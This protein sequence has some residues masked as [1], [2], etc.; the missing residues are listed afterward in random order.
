MALLLSVLT[1]L[2]GGLASF[3]RQHRIERELVAFAVCR[4]Q[5]EAM[6]L[7]P[8]AWPDSS[9]VLDGPWRF[10]QRVHHEGRLARYRVD[11]YWRESPR[12]AITLTTD[13]YV[14]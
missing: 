5:L 12:P 11:T 2:V 3:S 1:P 6:L 4:R 14:P 9:V 8:E 13:R 10:L 7:D